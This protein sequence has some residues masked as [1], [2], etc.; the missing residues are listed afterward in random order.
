MGMG[1]PLFTTARAR[2]SV[3]SSATGLSYDSATGIFSLT[4]GYEIPASGSYLKADGSID[5]SAPWVIATQSIT[6]TAGTLTAAHLKD[7]S[8]TAGRVWFS[9]AGG[10]AADSANLTFVDGQSL[11]TTA[12]SV[13]GLSN[14]NVQIACDS[15]AAVQLYLKDTRAY[16]VQPSASF[17]VQGKYNDAD[18]LAFFMQFMGGK[19]NVVNDDKKGYF[20]IRVNN[21]T[22][23][24]EALRIYSMKGVVVGGGAATYA[25]STGLAIHNTITGTGAALGLSVEGFYT[26][27]SGYNAYGVLINPT[28]V[29]PNTKGAYFLNTYG[30]VTAGTGLTVAT[31]VNT[32]VG[33]LT[34]S[35]SGT[36]TTCYGLH[37][38]E[39]TAGATNYS[40]YVDGGNS[41]FNGN[42]GIGTIPSYQ[43]HVNGS[44]QQS[45]AVG[46]STTYASLLFKSGSTTEWNIRNDYD[47]SHALG[48]YGNAGLNLI[49]VSQGGNVGIGTTS[50]GAKLDVYSGAIRQTVAPASWPASGSGAEMFYSDTLGGVLQGYNRATSAYIPVTLR[51]SYISLNPGGTEVLR[52]TAGNLG[53]GTT[54]PDKALEI[55]SATGACLRLTYNDSNGS[56]A[57]CVDFSVDSSGNLTIDPSGTTITANAFTVLGSAGSS[58]NVGLTVNQTISAAGLVAGMILEGTYTGAGLVG[59]G[60]GMRLNPTLKSTDLL[61]NYGLYLAATISVATGKSTTSYGMNLAALSKTGTGTVTTCYGLQV[62]K[63]T[64]GSTNWTISASGGNSRFVGNTSFGQS[65][66]PTA[67]IHV[68]ACTADADTAS[69]KIEAGT[70]ATSPVSGNIES[71]GTHLY[72]TD[73]GNTRKQLDN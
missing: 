43:L 23:L 32:M 26:S 6:L 25:G 28:L 16:S 70:V 44:G 57:N 60:Y 37:V 41:R 12:L 18:A 38:L 10:Q 39:Q 52:A 19:E 3:S 40:I 55:N 8:L 48:I 35:G 68:G 67:K 47:N 2:A 1:I 13:T 14:S 9:A 73:S 31:A 46:S 42:V 53:I 20:S 21:G 11:V 65:S 5:L 58:S 33:T 34:K 30:T 45:I 66:A 69:I 63:Q 22:D 17:V 27:G 51:G 71:D 56:A 4:G 59:V 54:A 36:I 49:T 29:P 50:P 24:A 7:T 62:V 15:S 64:I 72:W 61:S